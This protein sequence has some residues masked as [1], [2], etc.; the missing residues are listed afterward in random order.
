M[1]MYNVINEMYFLFRGIPSDQRTPL[2][3]HFV[4]SGLHANGISGKSL[5]YKEKLYEDDSF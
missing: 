3:L 2:Q 1:P 5:K 4:I